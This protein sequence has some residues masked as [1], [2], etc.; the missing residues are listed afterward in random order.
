ME[1]RIHTGAG[2]LRP[3]E[4]A[5][6]PM[7]FSRSFAAFSQ[8]ILDRYAIWEKYPWSDA[9][10]RYL[11][12]E[13]QEEALGEKDPSSFFITLQLLKIYLENEQG[14]EKAAGEA[15]ET[16]EAKESGKAKEA[17][18]ETLTLRIET[19][20]RRLKAGYDKYFGILERL[21]REGRQMPQEE[22]FRIWGL[23]E[24]EAGRR[25]A[26][27]NSWDKDGSRPSEQAVE[28][29]ALWMRGSVMPYAPW[30]RGH[31]TP[32]APWGRGYIT[33][34]ALG[35]PSI[36]LR[37][38]AESHGRMPDGKT[39][40]RES[41]ERQ[42]REFYTGIVRSHVVREMAGQAEYRLGRELTPS[43]YQALKDYGDSLE[44]TRLVFY[45]SRPDAR[46][47]Q[48]TAVQVLGLAADAADWVENK[49]LESSA[50]PERRTE[51]EGKPDEPGA[52]E[53][54]GRLL[55]KLPD[56]VS[57]AAVRELYAESVKNAGKGTEER[58]EE[59]EK[60]TEEP[61][62]PQKWA[63][64]VREQHAAAPEGYGENLVYW[65]ESQDFLRLSE[66]WEQSAQGEKQ[67]LLERIPQAVRQAFFLWEKSGQEDGTSYSKKIVQTIVER[68]EAARGADTA[69]YSETFG[70]AE[71]AEEVGR[72]LSELPDVIS[73]MAVQE[74]YAG[75]TG[76]AGEEEREPKEKTVE[77]R[78]QPL[79][80]PED[81]WGNLV[82][83]MEHESF[84]PLAELWK[85]SA[86]EERTQLLRRIPGA[87]RQAA[88]WQEE[89]G[90]EDEGS[91]QEKILEMIV[92]KLEAVQDLETIRHSGTSMDPETRPESERLPANA[93]I[94]EE[95][96]RLLLELPEWISRPTIQELYAKSAGDDEKS[97][98]KP[99]DREI[100]ASEE[101]WLAVPEGYGDNLVYRTENQ[102]SLQ[103]SVLWER[104]GPEERDDLLR[105][106]LPAVRQAFVLEKNG[107]ESVGPRR[108]QMLEA[109]LERMEAFQA[110]ETALR[111]GV[112]QSPGTR[113]R[114]EMPQL[115][116][117]SGTA[118]EVGRLLS[119][120]PDWI[121]RTAAS[122]LNAEGV[123]SAGKGE[124]PEN[125][126]E[127]AL[128]ARLSRPESY[129]GDLVY[130]LEGQDSLRLS[131]LWEQ[132][133]PEERDNLL[134][135]IPKAVGQA[136][137]HWE[138]SRRETVGPRQEKV[139]QT[140]VER[141]KAAGSPETR[142]SPEA[143][144]KDSET[145]G[146]GE[147]SSEKWQYAAPGEQMLLTALT[148]LVPRTD[149]P[150]LTAGTGT[151]RT[152]ASYR[153][154]SQIQREKSV[155]LS[156]YPNLGESA[157][158]YAAKA[159][160]PSDIRQ[161]DGG[162]EAI[163]E[164]ESRIS[165][166]EYILRQETMER[167]ELERRIK[168]RENRENT[169]WQ[170]ANMKITPKQGGDLSPDMLARLK[171]RLRKERI[172]YGAD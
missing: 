167:E 108:K 77:S 17:E 15:K 43:E 49:V 3:M 155:F 53:E 44:R 82:Y 21:Y 159:P 57:R 83:R 151:S 34:Y 137:F 119:E 55:S 157:I 121:S 129:G 147:R 134:R 54:I 72:L 96:G 70:S 111:P 85:Q 110:S 84:L 105:H 156:A 104:S 141:L 123:R 25:R 48:E 144:V 63:A 64:E 93:E 1:N 118:E 163:Q 50:G 56:V 78:E 106:I 2:V 136:A 81:Y 94:A 22:Y 19:E 107:Q 90:Q 166:Q 24:R 74:L 62:N 45:A 41:V 18:Q 122:Q 133:T 13:K 59:P 73:R 125:G 35:A 40:F 5:P 37:R 112:P 28:A 91:D 145:A 8:D 29:S 117:D 89:S 140:I 114:A 27:E 92:E 103:L 14:K 47:Y 80:L 9:V 68:I 23:L 126:A 154:H 142:R 87:I 95:I 71:T 36:R 135:R 97:G 79:A 124:A 4:F 86:P 38:M 67:R 52:L 10:I 76:Y 170:S 164:L 161:K 30:G 75:G 152:E 11:E 12:Q 169:L 131:T 113:G 143:S 168:N 61:G 26:W 101:P 172:R 138:E 139:L 149:R 130:R 39:L 7:G 65:I 60:G 20:L 88:S 109:L 162:T 46:L 148:W 66:L 171:E 115:P 98:G 51:E 153:L 58:A 158:V 16:G 146:P 150:L 69:G 33:P 42:Q 6:G 116:V 100:K 99:E 127:E 102:D 160:N 128:E 120:L 132:S 32:Y 165:R 31:I